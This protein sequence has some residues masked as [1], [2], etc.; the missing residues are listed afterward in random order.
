[1]AQP[2]GQRLPGR[3]HHHA[4][5]DPVLANDLDRC[6]LIIDAAGGRPRALAGQ[7][8]LRQ[9]TIDGGLDCRLHFRE[10]GVGP[11]DFR[12]GKGPAAERQCVS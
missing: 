9:T 12:A 1:M 10:Q 11:L 3:M 2:P 5:F 6:D 8:H 7:G 4:R